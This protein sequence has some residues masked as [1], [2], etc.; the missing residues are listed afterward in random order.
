MNAVYKEKNCN[1]WYE[2]YRPICKDSFTYEECSLCSGV[3]LLLVK[4][5]IY[6][7]SAYL[8]MLLEQQMLQHV[9]GWLY[10]NPNES[11]CGLVIYRC[12]TLCTGFTYV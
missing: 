12:H 3:L 6:S 7:F 5:C 2:Q 1:L 4:L 10:N 8:M 11:F 9:A